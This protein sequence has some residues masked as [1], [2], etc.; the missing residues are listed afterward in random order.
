[1]DYDLA[2]ACMQAGLKV[3]PTNEDKTPACE[4][5]HTAATTN[6]DVYL[7]LNANKALRPGMP[8]TMNG[9][10]GMDFDTYNMD[11]EQKEFWRPKYDE[12]LKDGHLIQKTKSG[13]FHLICRAPDFKIPADPKHTCLLYTSPSPRDS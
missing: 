3:F 1:M 6:P 10:V 9:L 8:M 12:W 4:G 5:G 13:G 2:H 7:R 11:F